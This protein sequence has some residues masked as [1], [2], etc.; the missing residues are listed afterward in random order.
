MI[1]YQQHR[2][3]PPVLKTMGICCFLSIFSTNYFFYLNFEWGDSYKTQLVSSSKSTSQTTIISDMCRCEL[4]SID[5]LDSIACIP[6]GTDLQDSISQGV[7]MR[8]LIRDLTTVKG[9]S[10]Y[11]AGEPIGKSMQYTAIEAYKKWINNG[12]L[13]SQN[14][15]S[16][17]IKSDLYSD[18]VEKNL[19]YKD[20]FFHAINETDYADSIESYALQ[21]SI[22]TQEKKISV[23]RE[24]KNFKDKSKH[25]GHELSAKSQLLMFAHICRIYF[26]IRSPI[27]QS[28]QKYLTT[29]PAEDA[30]E[31]K[32]SND[33]LRISL[34]VRRADSCE[35]ETEGDGDRYFDKASELN[36]TAQ[37]TG[38]RFCYNTAVYMNALQKAKKLAG[39]PSLVVYLSTDYAGELM[40][41]IRDQF[42]DLYRSST[43]K[44]LNFPRDTF[45][46]Q[47]SIE[48][49]K[50]DKKRPFLGETAVG[51]LWHLSHGQVFIG[52]MGMLLRLL[53]L[54]QEFIMCVL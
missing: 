23:K 47:N 17:F 35:H 15:Y 25:A 37:V 46:Y 8:N 41:Q 38:K 14:R 30:P 54:N 22:I 3:Y 48:I 32:N 19:K 2:G 28:Y 29:I 36:S 12:V 24:L 45:V 11:L 18:C 21:E 27:I 9:I 51:D 1:G 49:G 34:H 16:I 13:S 7:L 42:P 10:H 43:W 6:R 44:Y 39:G 52:H 26:N 40:D 31:E 20:C 50:H 53:I 5:C 4:L 33:V